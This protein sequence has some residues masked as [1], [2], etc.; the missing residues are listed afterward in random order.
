M[1]G[2]CTLGT[3]DLLKATAFYD[4]LMEKFGA[5]RVLTLDR[6]VFYGVSSLELGVL[7]PADGQP[8]RVG[9]GNMVALQAESRGQVE[10]LYA[11]ALALGASDE[12]APGVRGADPDGFYGAYFRDPEGNK[13]CVYRIGPA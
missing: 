5:R 12:G 11:Q 4:V 1:I 6:G 13:L 7:L 9:N 8:A 10:D 2:Y 3:N